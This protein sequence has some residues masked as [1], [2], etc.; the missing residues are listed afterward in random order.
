MQLGAEGR[1]MLADADGWT[2]SGD[3][4]LSHEGDGDATDAGLTRPGSLSSPEG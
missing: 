2:W 3:V 4:V 1:R